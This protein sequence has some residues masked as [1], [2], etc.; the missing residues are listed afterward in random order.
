M[1]LSVG[2]IVSGKVVNITNFGTFIEIEGGQNGL[3][4]I[5]EISNDYVENVSDVLKKGQEVKA[6]VLSND[7]GKLSLSIKQTL[8]KKEFVKQKDFNNKKDFNSKKDFNNK[9]DF[10]K[11]RRDFSKPQARKAYTWEGERTE[12]QD[13]SFEDKISRFLKE[14]TEKMDQM[15]FKENR[16]SSYHSK[17]GDYRN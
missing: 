1:T 17:K 12:S 5:S 3:V 7:N 2:D 15:K 10:S 11:P 13:L 9:K 8:P 16:R 14:S 4:H 6:K